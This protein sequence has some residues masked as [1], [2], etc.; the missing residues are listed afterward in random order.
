M[1]GLLLGLSFSGLFAQKELAPVSDP[2]AGLAS[3]LGGAENT[4][5]KVTVSSESEQAATVTVEFAG[6]Q[7]KKYIMKGFLLTNIK[8]V[9]VELE[10]VVVDVPSSGNSVEFT[11]KFKQQQKAYTQQY[12]ETVQLGIVVMDASSPLASVSTNLSDVNIG[13]STFNYQYPKKWRIGGTA[14]MVVQVKLTPIGSAA[15]IRQ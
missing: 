14:S 5:K 3:I 10:P 9:P 12:L 2:S 7:D 8:K 15:S 6:F 11:F 13:G 1:I 4:I